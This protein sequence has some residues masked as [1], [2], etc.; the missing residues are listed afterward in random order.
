MATYPLI[1][2]T[3]TAIRF[4]NP[5]TSIGQKTIT[6]PTTFTKV[7]TGAEPGYCAIIRV[8][9]NGSDTPDLS[10]FKSIGTG[11]W[12]NTNGVVNQLWFVFDGV[13]YCVAITHPGTIV[14]GGGGG[15]GDTTPPTLVSGNATDSTH[16]TLVFSETVVPTVVGWTV[17]DGVTT[18]SF[19][20]V[21]GSGTTWTFVL[22]SGTLTS[23]MTLS[24]AYSAT[25]GN[26]LDSAGNEI[27]SLGPVGIT[28]SISGGGVTITD[29]AYTY[30][31]PSLNTYKDFSATPCANGDPI[32]EI[33]DQIR[34]SNPGSHP[35]NEDLQQSDATKTP[36]Y[37]AAGINGKP[38]IET[39]YTG[40]NAKYLNTQIFGTS[41]V[42]TF[43]KWVV[44][45][46]KTAVTGFTYIT[47]GGQQ[48]DLAINSSTG[49]LAVYCGGS[50]VDT[51]YTVVVD[52]P[53]IV[54][55]IFRAGSVDVYVNG[56]SVGTGLAA[57]SDT[58]QNRFDI[59]ANDGTCPHGWYRQ[60]I[61]IASELSSSDATTIL[62][63]LKTD[64]GIS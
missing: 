7:T 61:T 30:H 47:L 9:A 60:Y 6:G 42:P 57:G 56:T 44:F 35:F 19:S 58:F 40:G 38:T 33:R 2:A 21:S 63:I 46:L 27:A 50:I 18:Y 62:N 23:S 4:D 36:T 20:S 41:L 31:N 45:E 54:R 3:T 16:I 52:T 55:A 17:G 22:A 39:N 64:N 13:D 49:K 25:T 51:S 12:D 26:T 37:V 32:S 28:N 59:G 14:G 10:A 11:A 29:V 53:F 24:I 48:F 34:V 1:V 43:E 8:V 15:G 5:V